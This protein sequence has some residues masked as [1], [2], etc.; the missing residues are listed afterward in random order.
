MRLGKSLS[1][2]SWLMLFAG[3]V[4]L[5]AGAK[6]APRSFSLSTS[7]TFL[8]GESVKVELP[9]AFLF[10]PICWAAAVTANK[11]KEERRIFMSVPQPHRDLQAA[12]PVRGHRSSEERGAPCVDPVGEDH[13]IQS[14]GRIYAGVQVVS[15]L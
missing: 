7:R 15:S 3:S 6:D 5:P 9:S 4:A 10:W 12:H 8:P 14:I 11:S 1:F 13:V 2:A